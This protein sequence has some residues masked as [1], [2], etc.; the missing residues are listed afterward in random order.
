MFP[1]F[2]YVEKCKRKNNEYSKSTCNRH[3]TIGTLAA[4]LSPNALLSCY[5]AVATAVPSCH[6]TVAVYNRTVAPSSFP[7]CHLRNPIMPVIHSFIHRCYCYCRC[8]QMPVKKWKKRRLKRP[9]TKCQ[10]NTTRGG[11]RHPEAKIVVN[12]YDEVVRATPKPKSLS[13]K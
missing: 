5:L 3:H 8:C 11:P 9:Q 4:V 1:S 12:Q 2:E 13:K 7:L 6:R 10:I